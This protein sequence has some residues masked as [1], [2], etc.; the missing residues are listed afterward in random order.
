MFRQKTCLYLIKLSTYNWEKMLKIKF[1]GHWLRCSISTNI[2]TLS[3]ESLQTIKV[4][5]LLLLKTITGQF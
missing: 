2:V 4:D 3:S 1:T 5:F